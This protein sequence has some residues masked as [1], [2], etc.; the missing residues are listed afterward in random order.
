MLQPVQSAGLPATW[1]GGVIY[2]KEEGRRLI[3]A[4]YQIISVV[5]RTQ[6]QIVRVADAQL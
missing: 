2:D 3:Q 5:D 1:G 6:A 4:W